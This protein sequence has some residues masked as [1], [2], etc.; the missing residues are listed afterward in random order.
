MKVEDLKP[1]LIACSHQAKKIWEYARSFLEG[2]ADRFRVTFHQMIPETS[3][4]P[5]GKVK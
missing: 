1:T 2:N 5:N 3:R 4:L